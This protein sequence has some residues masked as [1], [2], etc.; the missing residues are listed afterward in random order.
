MDTIYFA[1]F[2]LVQSLWD[3][4]N[5]RLVL[6]E[7]VD[8]STSPWNVRK[9]RIKSWSL[10]NHRTNYWGIA[11]RGLILFLCESWVILHIAWSIHNCFLFLVATLGWDFSP[12]SNHGRWLN[13]HPV[14]LLSVILAEKGSPIVSKCV[15]FKSVSNFCDI[16]TCWDIFDIPCWDFKRFR[17]SFI[18]TQTFVGTI[19]VLSSTETIFG[20][21]V[22][23]LILLWHR[24]RILA[25]HLGRPL[26]EVRSH[27]LYLNLS[28]HCGVSCILGNRLESRIWDTSHLDRLML[29]LHG[30]T[31]DLDWV[32]RQAPHLSCFVRHSVL[33]SITFHMTVVRNKHTV[34]LTLLMCSVSPVVVVLVHSWWNK[35]FLINFIISHLK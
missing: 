7:I 16:W 3:C 10:F 11:T 9:V 2:S 29:S 23:S 31:I 21:V 12:H 27:A 1:G 26:S 34:P 13:F 24:V 33:P 18:L 19:V 5:D 28:C 14:C 8:I 15:Q 4:S 25:H 30:R 22:V 17:W 32:C 20:I 35:L 6:T